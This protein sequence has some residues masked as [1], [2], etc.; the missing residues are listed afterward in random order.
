[1][2]KVAL[3]QKNSNGKIK[4]WTI[5]VEDNGNGTS[6]IVVTTGLIDGKKQ[7]VRTTIS[8]GRNIGKAN[9]TTPYTQAVSQAESDIK[10]KI[11]RGYS[12]DI[13]NLKESDERGGEI[14]AVMKGGSYHPLGKQKQSSAKTLD[15]LKIKGKE[16][17]LQVKL[18]GLRCLI[19]VTKDQAKFYSS[20][21]DPMY[22]F[23]H[24]SESVI[25]SFNKIYDYVNSKYGVESYILDGEMYSHELPFEEISGLVRKKHRSEEDLIRQEKLQF[26][27]FDVVLD[28][29]YSTRYKLLDYFVDPGKVEKVD[30]K[31]IKADEEIIDQEFSQFLSQGYEGLMIRLL[32]IPYE[33]K[34][35]KQLLKYKPIMDEEFMIV[36]YKKSITGDTLGSIEFQ[37]NDGS[38]RTFFATGDGFSDADC[39]KIWDERH[40]HIGKWMTVKYLELTEQGKGVPRH[41]KFKGFR[42]G[43]SKD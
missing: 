25:K 22:A 19:H 26:H 38:E 31:F 37:M 17:A 27:I 29:G 14:K 24:I 2:Q 6:D 10:S 35:G 40:T 7:E 15:E 16:I 8:E 33:H 5:C 23:P 13:N 41:P 43:P 36:G 28:V 30:C 12:S 32:D 21:T 18:D 34:R 11:K 42:K 9:E 20:S 3:Y 4:E 1:M 39:Q